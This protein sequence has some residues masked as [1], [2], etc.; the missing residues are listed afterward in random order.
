[1]LAAAGLGIAYHAKPAAAA[2]ADAAVRHGDLTVLLWAQGI[3]PRG[4]D[5]RLTAPAS[6]RP[7]RPTVAP[8][9]A[10]CPRLCCNRERKAWG[11]GDG[12]TKAAA[13]RATG[14]RQPAVRPARGDSADHGAAAARGE[15]RARADD[16]RHHHRRA[17]AGLHRLPR[18]AD[19]R[20][21]VQP[22]ELCH[23]AGDAERRAELRRAAQ[24]RQSRRPR[25]PA[26]RRRYSP[27]S[28]TMPRSSA[29]SAA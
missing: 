19:P 18:L 21:E 1:M 14:P 10:L 5:P 8:A 29:G 26:V 7:P 24:P 6:D 9:F 27:S 28:C 15:G 2:A 25:R 4:V 22:A 23:R 20:R 11:V 3:A 12:H 16:R 13:G 17:G